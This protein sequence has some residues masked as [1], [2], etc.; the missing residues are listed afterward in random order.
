MG[1]PSDMAPGLRILAVLI[2]VVALGIGIGI[3]A[4]L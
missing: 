1:P 2:A 3:G 4:L